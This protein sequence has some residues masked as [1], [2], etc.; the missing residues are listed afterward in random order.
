M[1]LNKFKIQ[2]YADGAN[3]QDIILQNNNPLIKG[4]TTN[5]TLMRKAGILNY[6]LFAAQVLKKIRNVPISFEVF[7]DDPSSIY[8]Q[9]KTIAS[10]GSNV[11]VKIPI[12][13][14]KGDQLYDII[15]K[16][17]NEEV[18]LNI[19]A[20]LTLDQVERTVESLN[21]NIFS[22]ISVFAG[23]IADTGVD[24]KK[25]MN[26]A[27]TYLTRSPNAKLLWAS[28]RQAYNIIEAEEVGAD[29]ITLTPE[30]LNKANNFGKDLNVL[31][32]ETVQMFYEDA[33]KAGY[34]ID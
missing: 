33:K 25:I 28:P 3:Y 27:K 15:K 31:S 12:T 5:P 34:K 1:D 16:L 22:I 17:S 13:T 19:T 30:L 14:T 29:I 24:P 10:W 23:R 21:K 20:I 7:A 6:K 9:A 11:N 2:I 18:Q 32:M 4:F 8:D 26:E